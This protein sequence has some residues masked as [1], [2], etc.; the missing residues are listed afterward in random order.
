MTYEY[1]SEC[2]PAVPH[3]TEECIK[4]ITLPRDIPA[5]VYVSYQLTNFYQNHRR[6]IKSRSYKQLMGESIDEQT[7]QTMCDPAWSNSQMGKNVSVNN[8]TLEPDAVAYPCGLIA[9]SLFNDTFQITN[10]QSVSSSFALNNADIITIDSGN[11][12]WKTDIEYKYTNQPGT[13]QDIQWTDVE[14]CKSSLFNQV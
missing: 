4:T 11:I 7:A 12:A 1:S 13:W 3:P 5:P 8:S 10:Q 9:R 14:N 6:Y 2:G